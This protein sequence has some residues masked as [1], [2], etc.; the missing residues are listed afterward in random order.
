MADEVW[1]VFGEAAPE[2]NSHHAEAEFAFSIVW[3]D[4][5]VGTLPARQQ[6]QGPRPYC[7]NHVVLELETLTYAVRYPY[8]IVVRRLK[9]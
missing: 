4:L 9:K 1:C 5:E 8:S 3:D 2:N 6:M 7:K